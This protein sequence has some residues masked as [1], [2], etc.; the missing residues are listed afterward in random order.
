MTPEEVIATLKLSITSVFVPFSVSRNKAEKHLSLNWAVTVC[1]DG[2]PFATLDYS[3]GIG[4]C[5]SRNT[6]SPNAAQL[7]D[8]MWLHRA[9]AL[10]CETGF[11]ASRLVVRNGPRPDTKNLILPNPIDV[12]YCLISDSRVL[13]S[14]GFENWA[15]DLGYDTDSRKS[16]S[17]YRECLETAVK[18]NSALGHTGIGMLQRAFEDY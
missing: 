9:I 6:K 16:E 13:E 18:L 15:A 11:A 4:H 8:S 12:F 2:K 10:E 3:A 17:I 5:P 14:G 1:Q 7:P